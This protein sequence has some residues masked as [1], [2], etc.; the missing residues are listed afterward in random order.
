MENSITLKSR[1]ARL[2]KDYQSRLDALNKQLDNSRF[3]AERENI[4]KDIDQLKGAYSQAFQ[5]TETAI[6]EAEAREQIEASEQEAKRVANEL[7][8]KNRA[9]REW[10][11]AGGNP[12]QFEASWDTIRAAVLN[13]RVIASLTNKGEE[14][15]TSKPFTL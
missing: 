9:L 14:K 8:V 11:R 2:Q 15:P 12:A 10:V 3:E 5:R 7:E 1:L 6:K 13:E 4:Q